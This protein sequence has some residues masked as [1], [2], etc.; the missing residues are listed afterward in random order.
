MEY[1]RAQL[2]R[3][4]RLAMKRASPSPMLVTL[5]FTV[6]VS[7]GTLLLNTIAG[8]LLT[9]GMNRYTA[10]FLGYIGAGYD[11]EEAAEQVLLALL[12]QGPGIVLAAGVGSFVLSILISLW[13]STMGVGYAGYALSMVRGENP[14]MGKIFCAIPRIGGVLITRIVAGLFIFLWTLLLSAGYVLVVLGVAVL[15]VAVESAALT[16]LLMLAATVAYV[17]GVIRVTLRYA[18][19][20][21]V[22]LDQG[23]SGMDAV[24]ESKRL[25]QNNTGRAFMLQLSFFGWHL[26]MVGIIYIG[27]MI[28]VV[29]VGVWVAVNGLDDV[30]GLLASAGMAVLVMAAAAIG[31]TVLNLWLRPYVTGSMARFYDWARGTP[32]G[33]TGGGDANA[34]GWNGSTGYTWSSG[35]SAGAGTGTKPGDP[36]A[37]QGPRDDPWK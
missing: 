12:S 23:L 21:Y 24:Q 34:G 17:L 6:V 1:D 25:M 11:V 28:G 16:V 10:L 35:P 9:G 26:L 8:R 36:P 33:F 15:A 13:Q 32:D 19:V 29:S 14:T 20:D 2:K 7:V 22:F 31:A 27:V 5:L 30:A 3:S 4:V 37:P 18:L